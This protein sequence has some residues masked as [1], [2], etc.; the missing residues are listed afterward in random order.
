M[1][2]TTNE[3]IREMFRNIHAQHWQLHL[4]G[5]RIVLDLLWAKCPGCGQVANGL[6]GDKILFPCQTEAVPVV[7][8][9][10]ELDTSKL[11]QLSRTDPG[12][13]LLYIKH[14]LIAKTSAHPSE[15]EGSAKL[16][17]DAESRQ[18]VSR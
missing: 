12:A 18:R 4:E 17:D 6:S 1:N 16:F 9:R 7:Y 3:V 10:H 2:N 8:T 14:W 13:A 11:E 5:D 15:H